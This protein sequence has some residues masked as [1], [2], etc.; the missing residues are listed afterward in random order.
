MWGTKQDDDHWEDKYLPFVI[1]AAIP[2]LIEGGAHLLGKY[3]EIREHKRQWQAEKDQEIFFERL[4]AALDRRIGEQ[5]DED[6][7]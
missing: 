5:G 3:L 7:S 4:N 1:L 6:D 2:A